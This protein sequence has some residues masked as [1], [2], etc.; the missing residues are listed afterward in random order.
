MITA[1]CGATRHRRPTLQ[2]RPRRTATHSALPPRTATP[3]SRQ[4]SHPRAAPSCHLPSPSRASRAHLARRAC[5][6]QAHVKSLFNNPA[7]RT[8]HRLAAV[9]SINWARI[10]AQIVYYVH[11][12]LKV[13]ARVRVRVR[14]RVR[15]RIVYY[16][17]AY[18]KV[19]PSPTSPPA[20]APASASASA[21][22]SASPSP[23]P[24]P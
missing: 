11:A 22:P 5:R 21:S 17:H 3:H 9:N 14:V 1:H 13:R 6:R 15:A 2:C 12:Y 20:P 7:F 24:Y 23:S 18:L 8:H 4:H 16:V 10:L 19:T